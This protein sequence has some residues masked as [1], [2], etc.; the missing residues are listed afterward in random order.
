MIKFYLIL[1]TLGRKDEID[2][3]LMSL[4]NQTYNNFEV[5][6]VDQNNNNILDDIIEKYRVFFPINHI[7]INEKGLSLARNVGIR[8]LNNQI[9]DTDEEFILAFPDDDC[10]YTPTLLEDVKNSFEESKYSIITGISVDKE[11]NK[12]SSGRWIKK[13]CEIK[14]DNIFMTAISITIFIK[15][16]NEINLYFDEKLGVGANYGSSE[17]TDYIFRYL[18]LG[19][20]ALYIPEK[21]KVIHPNKGVNYDDNTDRQRAYYYATGLGAFFNKHIIKNKNFCLFP[22]FIQLIFFRPIIGMVLGLLKFKINMFL[23]YKNV[24]WGRLKGFFFYE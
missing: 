2:Y 7:K 12:I 22:T 20:K 24:F 1:A 3:L 6:I 4:K 17:E 18:K 15:L 13:K 19:Y 8:Y 11:T 9:K 21:I 14:C 16:K 10:E 23:Y 5:I